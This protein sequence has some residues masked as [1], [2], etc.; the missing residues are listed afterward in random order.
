MKDIEDV[1]NIQ[2][3]IQKIQAPEELELRLRTALKKTTIQKKKIHRGLVAAI[4]T[5][6][7][8]FSYSFDTLAYY[9]KKMMGYD[10][11]V[12]GNIGELNE[13]GAGQ[14]IQRSHTFSNGVEV[15]LDGIMFDENELVAFYKIQSS[16]PKIDEIT[17]LME[18]NGIH[19]IRYPAQGGSGFSADDYTQIW[20]HSFEAPKFY[21]KWLS[22]DITMITTR[23]SNGSEQG[24]IKFTLDRNKAMKRMV[25]QDIGQ[26]VDIET[27]N[28]SLVSL[29]ASRLNTTI[30]GIIEPQVDNKQQIPSSGHR[31]LDTLRFDIFVDNA[32]YDTAYVGINPTSRKDFQAEVRGLPSE[33]DRIDFRNFRLVQMKMIDDSVD[34]T[35]DTKNLVIDED[36]VITRVYQED[37][38]TSVAIKSKGF[39]IMG[40]FRN[41]KQIKAVDES[42][43]SNLPASPE[44]LERVYRFEGQSPEM[45]LMFKG[46]SY[47]KYADDTT[48]IKV[49]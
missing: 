13:E 48:F 16:G 34:I 3:E 11:I 7:L 32:L 25:K 44:A 49:K 41:D 22:L 1:L 29:T 8:I 21:E 26:E 31:E 20:V 14:E 39:P 2:S 12:H 37:G 4:I 47:V 45:T 19:P 33:F 10:T 17:L 38:K 23:N 42:D 24:S 36:L 5:F 27:L 30:E 43:H 40:L 28:I 6:T 15:L 46:I 18:I 9:G 35:L